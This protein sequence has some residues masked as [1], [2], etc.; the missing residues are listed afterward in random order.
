ERVAGP[1]GAGGDGGHLAVGGGRPARRCRRCRRPT[2]HVLLGRTVVDRDGGRAGRVHLPR[3]DAGHHPADDTAHAG[4]VLI[5]LAVAK[6]QAAG[7]E[8]IAAVRATP[9]IGAVA[10][11][12][13]EREAAAASRRALARRV[14]VHVI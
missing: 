7:H 10:L 1:I 3:W 2:R 12:A 4:H 8:G 5:A 6:L 9:A 11:G 14:A 13:T